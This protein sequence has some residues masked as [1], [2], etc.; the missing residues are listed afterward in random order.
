VKWTHVFFNNKTFSLSGIQKCTEHGEEP[1]IIM[2]IPLR[3]G[4]LR[5]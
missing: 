2:P 5:A 4:F 1:Y 3:L